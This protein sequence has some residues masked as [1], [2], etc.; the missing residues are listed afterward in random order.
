MG[1]GQL[2][3]VRRQQLF[4]I[5]RV[6]AERLDQLAPLA[7]AQLRRQGD[8]RALGLLLQ[9]ES[10][11]VQLRSAG[12]ERVLMMQPAAELL[13]ADGEGVRIAARLDLATQRGAEPLERLERLAG[14]RLKLVPKRRRLRAH[15]AGDL[16]DELPAAAQHAERGVGEYRRRLVEGF[17]GRVEEGGDLTEP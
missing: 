16:D 5:R 6:V 7:S 13:F 14:G 8:Q 9:M 17:P 12:H 4:D 2:F 15:D 3:L 1:A 11:A 10:V